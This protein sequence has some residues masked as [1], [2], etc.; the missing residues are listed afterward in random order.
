MKNAFCILFALLTTT[1]TIISQAKEA[2][3]IVYTRAFSDNDY[4]HYHIAVLQAAL[5]ITAEYGTTALTPHPHPMSQSRQMVSL[6]KGEADVMWSVTNRTREQNLIPIRFP[7]LKGYAG[8]RVLIIAPQKQRDLPPTLSDSQL[9]A[10]SFVQGMDWPDLDVLKSNGYNAY[11]EDWSVWF[12][13]MYSMVEK[14]LVDGFPRN[15]IEVHR[16]L[17]RHSDKAIVLEQN[18]LLIYP[19]YEFFFVSPKKPNL[20][21]RLRTGL[22]RLLESGQLNRF[23]NEFSWH[24]AANQ[25]VDAGNR[26]VHYLD[27]PSIPYM[28]DYARWDK[29]PQSA[30]EALKYENIDNL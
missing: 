30:I 6:H 22:I 15:I 8:Y 16:D 20:A 24:Q 23:F 5:D 7:L 25:L 11:G 13:T 2:D 21:K 17:A 29:Y 19:N 3:E 1:Q 28:L 26:E 14:H 10:L 18:H 12:S 9:K 4:G 27:N